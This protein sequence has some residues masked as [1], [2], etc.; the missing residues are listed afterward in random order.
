ML[1]RVEFGGEAAVLRWWH[2][3]SKQARPQ[4][5]A[6]SISYID[7]WRRTAQ[8]AP[9]ARRCWRSLGLWQD[10]IHDPGTKT[11]ILSL[12]LL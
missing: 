6:A 2:V 9:V 12:N 11:A 4:L 1:M 7:W 5:S 3:R 8:Q 10:K